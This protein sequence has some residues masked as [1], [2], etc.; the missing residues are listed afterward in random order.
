M[1]PYSNHLWTEVFEGLSMNWKVQLAGRRG[2]SR[3]GRQMVKQS[4]LVLLC[5]TGGSPQ[6]CWRSGRL[7]RNG[8]E[9]MEITQQ[10]NTHGQRTRT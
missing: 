10:Q 6:T 1:H 2:E 4:Q 3:G 8:V 9:G 5:V 7:D